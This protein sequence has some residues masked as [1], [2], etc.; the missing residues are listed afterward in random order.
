MEFKKY[1]NQI[2]PYNF[3]TK[4]I[5]KFE[6]CVSENYADATITEVITHEKTFIMEYAPNQFGGLE[7]INT[8]LGETLSFFLNKS[9]ELIN[10]LKSYV[11]K[12]SNE[13]DFY[14]EVIPSLENDL[15]DILQKRTYIAVGSNPKRFIIESD[16][17]PIIS[18]EF[19]NFSSFIEEIKGPY[20]DYLIKLLEE[21]D[22][23]KS[24][25]FYE[26]MEEIKNPEFE[27][28]L[29]IKFLKIMIENFKNI[30]EICENAFI[31]KDEKSKIK[32]LN[33]DILELPKVKIDFDFSFFSAKPKKYLY[34]FSTLEELCYITFYHLT[35]NRKCIKRCKN[36]NKYFVPAHAND[37]YCNNII[38]SKK[39]FTKLKQITTFED[40]DLKDV[41]YNDLK[42]CANVGRYISYHK[43]SRRKSNADILF[44]NLQMRLKKRIAKKDENTVYFNDLLEKIKK[45]KTKELEKYNNSKNEKYLYILQRYLTIVDKQYQKKFPRETKNKYTSS[46]YWYGGRNNDNLFIT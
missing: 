27:N 35:L 3:N 17:F 12:Y 16:I 46:K 13:K 32:K 30:K 19:S 41:I 39:T 22:N 11:E 21:T 34:T 37:I 44:G 2:I 5:Y 10:C 40:C 9:N 43:N 36:C 14:N 6:L 33:Y 45:A 31:E 42:T 20:L 38:N 28:N 7:L 8:N 26:H 18:K 25:V 23:Q 4:D 1:F 24:K 15:R 29:W